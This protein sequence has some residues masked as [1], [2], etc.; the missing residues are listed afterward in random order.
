[1]AGRQGCNLVELTMTYLGIALGANMKKVSTW[2]PIITKIQKKLGM[3]K[4]KFLSRAGRLVLIKA[5]IN[6]MPLYYMS[7][8]KIPKIVQQIIKIQREFFWNGTGSRKGLPLIK[9]EIIQK[10]KKMGV[11]GVDDIIVKNAA[12]LFKWWW[13]FCRREHFV[14]KTI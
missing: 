3:W 7:L 1:M 14:E 4:S 12:L 6:S 11:L 2:N 9:W 5:D 10:P 13:R 8:F